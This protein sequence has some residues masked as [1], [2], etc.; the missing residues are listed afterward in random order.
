MTAKD[1]GTTNATARPST[2]TEFTTFMPGDRSGKKLKCCVDAN[3]V[4]AIRD[5]T[6]GVTI[7]YRS[8]HTQEGALQVAERY[9][10]V[11][12]AIM[13]DRQTGSDLQTLSI[14]TPEECEAFFRRVAEYAFDARRLTSEIERALPQ[15]LD[16]YVRS[17]E[18]RQAKSA[19]GAP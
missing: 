2:L 4:V 16:A 6:Q 9:D 13:R 18:K 17:T 11:R 5:T 19:K 15:V 3:C 10:D 14:L 8:R 12:D 7:Q 1:T